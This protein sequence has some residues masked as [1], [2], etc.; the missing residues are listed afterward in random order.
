MSYSGVSL[1]I[2][3]NCMGIY[4]YLNNFFQLKKSRLYTQTLSLHSYTVYRRE[5][6]HIR[7]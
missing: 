3:Y 4:T 5:M 6:R 2:S 7:K 1:A